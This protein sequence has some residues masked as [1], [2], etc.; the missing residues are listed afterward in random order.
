MARPSCRPSVIAPCK[1]S[2][3]TLY[4]YFLGDIFSGRKKFVPRSKAQKAYCP[5][6][7]G[8]RM[9]QLLIYIR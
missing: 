6:I 1:F 7:D 4:S 9:E 3:L 5:H 8:L 2:F